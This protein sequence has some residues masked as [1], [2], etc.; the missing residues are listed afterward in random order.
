[1][2][3][4]YIRCVIIISNVI[5]NVFQCATLTFFEPTVYLLRKMYW[6]IAFRGASGCDIFI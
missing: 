3:S 4:I 6:E 2:F 5:L 1:M